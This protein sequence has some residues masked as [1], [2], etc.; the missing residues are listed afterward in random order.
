M[1]TNSRHLSPAKKAWITRKAKKGISK[2]QIA[3]ELNLSH[4]TVYYWIKAYP[5]KNCGW[6]G[7]RGKTLDVLQE[8][9]AKGYAISR[10]FSRSQYGVL[11]K[12]FPTISKISIYN[13]N[14]YFLEGKEEVAVR[15]YLERTNKKIISYQE[16]KQVTD[17]FKVNLSK[18]DKDAFLLKKRGYKESKNQGVP[19]GRPLRENDDS[20]SF[21][22]IRKYC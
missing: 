2:F 8:I 4:Q 10:G 22:Y 19:K 20:F 9:V 7:I 21:F 5:S 13:R 18:R 3:E 12:Y 16:L 11:R 17:V 14:I 6:P 15:A 1:T